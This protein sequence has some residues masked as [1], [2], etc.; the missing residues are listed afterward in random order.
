MC[1]CVCVCV[2]VH[3]C[4]CMCVNVHVWV[5]DCVHA[6]KKVLNACVRICQVYTPSASMLV[7]LASSHEQSKSIQSMP[8]LHKNNEID[9]L[10]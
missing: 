10:I 8:V 7:Y 2:H 5:C 6:R 3:V 9:A 1:V 4:M